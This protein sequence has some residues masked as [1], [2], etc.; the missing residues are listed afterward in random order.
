MPDRSTLKLDLAVSTHFELLDLE[1]RRQIIYL[2]DRINT[3]DH[4]GLSAFGLEGIGV[5]GHIIT[6]YSSK[7][8]SAV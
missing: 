3:K 6:G 4:V 8:S 5:F 2:M 1:I 7:R